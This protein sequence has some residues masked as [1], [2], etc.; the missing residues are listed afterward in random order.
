MAE[1]EVSPGLFGLLVIVEANPGL[2]QTEL[3]AAAQLDRSSMVPAL[4]KLESAWWVARRASGAGPARQRAVADRRRCGVL[5]QLK[6]RVLAHERRLARQLTAGERQQLF[7]LLARSCL[8]RASHDNAV[9]PD[10]R[11]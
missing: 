6:Q 7:E 11:R 4:D 1:L 2:K 3:A 10:V 5:R 8:S 9:A